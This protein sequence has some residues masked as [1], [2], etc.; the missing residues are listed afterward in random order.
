MN[1]PAGRQARTSQRT[2]DFKL[3]EANKKLLDLESE[4]KLITSKEVKKEII[5]P[6]SKKIFN[7]ISQEF[8]KEVENNNKLTR[9]AS[10]RTRINSFIEFTQSD[11]IHFKEID[12]AFLRKYMTFLKTKKATRNAQLLILWLL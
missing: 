6:L 8:I 11:N 3:G 4:D 9:L 10:D 12:E 7:E 2:L 5:N 1:L